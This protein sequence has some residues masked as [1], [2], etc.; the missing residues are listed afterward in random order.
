MPFIQGQTSSTDCPATVGMRVAC[1]HY[2]ATRP[3]RKFVGGGGDGGGGRIV[4]R[5]PVGLIATQFTDWIDRRPPGVD[6]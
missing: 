5:R 1:N 6:V 3:V 4:I 2:R